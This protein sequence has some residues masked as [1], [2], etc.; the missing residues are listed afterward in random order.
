MCP[1]CPS[2]IDDVIPI[3]EGCLPQMI[4]LILMTLEETVNP[5]SST[6]YQP[7]VMAK[8]KGRL[9]I[10][11]NVFCVYVEVIVD[12]TSSGIK[13]QAKT[14]SRTTRLCCLNVLV[15]FM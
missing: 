14:T 8:R 9:K 1:M 7:W 12:E 3:N 13:I 5:H 11:C 10:E 2:D 6:C 15:I 4:L